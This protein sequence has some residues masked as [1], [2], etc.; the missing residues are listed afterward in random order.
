MSCSSK[1]PTGTRAS[2]PTT[3]AAALHCQ[4]ALQEF[5]RVWAPV[6][7]LAAEQVAVPAALKTRRR[8]PDPQ[9]RRRRLVHPPA[10]RRR[11]HP[12]R[13]PRSSHHRTRSRPQRPRRP[14]RLRPQHRSTAATPA[15][16]ATLRHRHP[17]A[18]AGVLGRTAVVDLAIAAHYGSRLD[19][20]AREVQ[21]R[22]IAE[23]RAKAGLQDVTVN[24]TVDD[25]IT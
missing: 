4:A 19:A 16:R 2:S 13:R 6:R 8:Q 10:Q 9:A 5:S 18:A 3:S 25:V 17:Q 14:G 24:V 21:Q 1:P 23:L 7:S 20:I 12:H 11:S 22:A 15:E